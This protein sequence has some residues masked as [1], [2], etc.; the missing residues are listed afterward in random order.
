MGVIKVCAFLILC[1]IAMGCLRY[2]V[3][4]SLD[5]N[6]DVIFNK[7][8]FVFYI[9][10]IVFFIILCAIGKLLGKF[11][12]GTLFLFGS[13]VYLI[14]G[15]YLIL[16]IDG[17]IHGDPAVIFGYLPVF[18][19]GD[20]HGLELS[21]YFN[22]FPYQLGFLTFERLLS[23]LCYNTKFFFFV[24]LLLVIGSD[25]FLMK[26]TELIYGSDE[27]AV[28]YTVVFSF[29]FLP[30]FFLITWLYGQIPGLFFL[31]FAV[32]WAVR[33]FQGKGKAV[34]NY[35]FCLLGICLSCL[36]KSNYYIAAIA[37][38]IVFL[39]HALR[40][41]QVGY[42][43]A[44][45]GLIAALFLS[46]RGLYAYYRAI[47]GIKFDTSST[48]MANLAMG[49]QDTL[50]G[51]KGGWYNG[52][53]FDIYDVAGQ[54]NSRIA[55]IARENLL[56]QIDRLHSD[57]SKT[58]LFFH[59][60]IVSTWCAPLFSSVWS[61]PLPHTGASVQGKILY[62]LYTNGHIYLGVEF[63]M[64]VILEFLYFFSILVLI[65]KSLFRDKAFNEMEIFGFLYLTGGFLFHLISE[66]N[67][68]YVVMYVYM[69]IPYL[70]YG[71]AKTYHSVNAFITRE[72]D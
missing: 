13:A 25:F 31:V 53:T 28:R 67:C 49:L 71:M 51:H 17:S 58:I 15:V 26:T 38:V 11:K 63:F 8:G 65:R 23:L 21:Y 62:S 70:G 27:L 20:Y 72:R 32:F 10:L 46:S 56:E 19:S 59:D 60:K 66:T 52:Y 29:L 3:Y 1:I 41:R 33:L 24:N 64:N 45:V 39:L 22:R 54:S 37:L 42:A 12:A 4:V 47:S 40:N 18:N 9:A 16:H 68:L 69:L 6:E 48:V 61:G 43:V 55:G 44:A 34:F 14:A 2:R 5:Y 35:F 57:T 30:M 50:G 7:N 36:M